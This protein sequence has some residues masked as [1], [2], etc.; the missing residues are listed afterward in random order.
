MFAPPKRGA[1]SLF[2]TRYNF[3]L[4]SFGCMQVSLETVQTGVTTNAHNVA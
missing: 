1:K 2:K 3:F 4:L